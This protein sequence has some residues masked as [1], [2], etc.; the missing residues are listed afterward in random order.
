MLGKSRVAPKKTVTIPRLELNAAAVACKLAAL[1]TKQLPV[2]SSKTTF[3]TDSMAVLRFINN[4][5]SRFKVFVANRLSIIHELSQPNQWRYVNTKE[6]PAD[7]ASRGASPSDNVLLKF[8]S[9]GPSFLHQAKPTN[10]E[11]KEFDEAPLEE[12]LNEVKTVTATGITE[13]F[14]AKWLSRWSE[15]N[16]LVRCTAYIRR[17][18]VPGFIRRLKAGQERIK[19]LSVAELNSAELALVKLSQHD[20]FSQ[21]IDRLQ[22]GRPVRLSSRIL[23]LN[24][25]MDKDGVVRV[26][27]RIRH[28]SVPD[29]A[30]HP[31]ILPNSRLSRL[32]LERIHKENG[33]VGMKQVQANAQEKFW[34]VKGAA[35][36]KNVTQSCVICRKLYAQPK[37]Q[38]MADLPLERLEANKP[39]FTNTGI[40]YFGPIEVKQGRS[41]VK[42]YGVIFT[43]LV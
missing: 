6:N 22:K 43:C 23:Q 3:W 40:D 35:L 31:I 41:M 14:S 20:A 2:D 30:K 42:R 9:Q 15:Y 25:I 17:F 16:K 10:A 21:E 26:G 12:E 7:V 1:V 36:A 8:W 18:T 4:K 29:Q 11:R 19:S 34:I 24:P 33:H 28:S 38:L 13:D 27:G 37:T 39:P 5:H 32:L